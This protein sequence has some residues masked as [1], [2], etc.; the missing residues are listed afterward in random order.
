MLTAQQL[1]LVS[2]QSGARNI[3][4]VE[5]D[6]ILTHLLQLMHERGLADHLA[7]KGG[8]ML[9]KMIFGPQ[10]RLSTDLDFT[11]ASDMDVDTMSLAVADALQE[12]YRGLT[13][14]LDLDRDWYETEDGCGINPNCCHADNPSGRHIKIQISFREQ[15]VLPV[16]RMPQLPQPY[17]GMLDFTPVDVPCLAVEEII[18]E[19]IRAACERSKPRDLYDLAEISK[20][21]LDHDTV[22]SLAVWKLWKSGKVGLSYERFTVQVSNGANYDL[23]DLKQLLRKDQQPDLKAMMSTAINGFRFLGQ[24]TAEESAAAANVGH[25]EPESAKR[26]ITAL[27]TR[28][29]LNPGFNLETIGQ[30]WIR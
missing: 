9:R 27:Q 16:T 22:R 28:R 2:R 25:R 19:K 4:N 13:F 7:F 8:T 11:N 21:P 30:H 29:E 3:E 14:D 10:G 17:F 18:S 23:N 1:Q 20:R 12:P 5:I 15:P 26:L 24:L 6:I